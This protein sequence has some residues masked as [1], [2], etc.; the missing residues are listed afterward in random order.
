MSRSRAASV[1]IAAVVLAAG[2]VWA[3][4]ISSSA[5]RE[6]GV[7]GGPA[8]TFVVLGDSVPAGS[9][10]R[11]TPFPEL[12]RVAASA[13]RNGDAYLLDDAAGG[14]TSGDVLASLRA[15]DTSVAAAL[16]RATTVFL[17]V[18]ANDFDPDPA[19]TCPPTG[20]CDRTVADTMQRNVAGTLARIAE[21]SGGGARVFVTGYWG[22]FLD[23]AVAADRGA[24]YVT[25]AR[26]VT[27]MVNDSLR[28]AAAAGGAHFVDLDRAF[29]AAAGASGDR[30]SLLASD[31]DHPSG[32]GHRLIADALL[33]VCACA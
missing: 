16:R 7:V 31:G 12:V 14:V 10:C 27:A 18:G 5:A 15:D 33:D 32:A 25:A 20:P 2:A 24:D 13:A 1:A 11:C 26:A 3:A 9:S 29:T 8:G 21:L 4:G 22:V 30:T 17:T 19:R 6:R 23:G 28:T